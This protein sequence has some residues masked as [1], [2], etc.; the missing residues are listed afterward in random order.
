MQDSL[1]LIVP[2]K[3]L[4][5]LP[6]SSKIILLQ[7]SSTKWGGLGLQYRL[8]AK[9]FLYKQEGLGPPFCICIHFV[10]DSFQIIIFIL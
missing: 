6:K 7:I 9:I 10:V 2:S 4:L 5:Q 1:V 8:P 3:I